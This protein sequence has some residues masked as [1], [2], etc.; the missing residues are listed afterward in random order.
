MNLYTLMP[1]NKTLNNRKLQK[2]REI[3]DD[4]SDEISKRMDTARL[5]NNFLS[6][7]DKQITGGH[8]VSLKSDLTSGYNKKWI[9][10]YIKKLADDNTLFASGD[11]LGDL[12][13]ETTSLEEKMIAAFISLSEY[14]GPKP[15]IENLLDPNAYFGLTFNM[16]SV[17]TGKV[18]SG[19]SGQTYAATALLC[20]AR[21]SLVNK[22]GFNKNIPQGIRFMPI[23]EAEGLG[24][25]FD[26]LYD[27]AKQFDYQILTMSIN[28]L[29]LFKQGEQFI[30]M[31]SN[32]RE[33]LEDVNNPPFGIFSNA[34]TQMFMTL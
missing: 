12:L 6:G 22:G 30:Y 24:S 27:I 1:T 3:L 32:N 14:R 18:N 31:L 15:K 21:L 16:E 10:L 23:D 19:S 17:A 25:N 34:D 33:S 29:G 4:V 2:I 8:R 26:M 5:I 13:G 28:P 9:D 20:I 11:S 7:D